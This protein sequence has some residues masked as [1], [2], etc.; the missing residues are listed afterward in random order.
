MR[1]RALEAGRAIALPATPCP[2]AGGSR[3]S[4]RPQADPAGTRSALEPWAC[5]PK[6]APATDPTP[7]LNTDERFR[8][9]RDVLRPLPESADPQT[10]SYFVISAV[11]Q[12]ATTSFETKF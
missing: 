11:S 6:P 9:R 2:R 3:G 1:R 8:S 7:M 5:R 12:Y 4:G 10:D